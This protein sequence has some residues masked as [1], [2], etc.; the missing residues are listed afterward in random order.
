MLAFWLSY[1]ALA[2]VHLFACLNDKHLKLRKITKFFLVPGLIAGVLLD[3]ALKGES[4]NALL[5]AGLTLGW[6]GDIYP[7][8][9]FFIGAG[10]LFGLGHLCYIAATLRF[11]LATSSFSALPIYVY[12]VFAAAVI[13]LFCL[14][15]FKIRK[16]LGPI[17]YLGAVYFSALA[18]ALLISFATGRYLLAAAFAVFIS[19]DIS[20]VV[21][22]F[23]KPIKYGDLLVM[24]TYIAAQTLICVSFMAL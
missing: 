5:L 15:Q 9:N 1:A 20:L 7:G 10:I 24:S 19:S 12:V 13:G 3:R 22:S 4:P 21:C 23:F 11:F 18:A 2:A 17:A 8:K 16:K 14:A 6:L